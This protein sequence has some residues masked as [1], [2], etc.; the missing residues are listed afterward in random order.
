MFLQVR[1]GV[2]ST[3]PRVI[4]FSSDPPYTRDDPAD[5]QKANLVNW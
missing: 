2:V 1:V 4:I 5:L 3:G